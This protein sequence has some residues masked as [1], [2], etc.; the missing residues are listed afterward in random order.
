MFSANGS[1]KTCALVHEVYWAAFGKNPVTGAITKSPCKIV[2]VLDASDKI[3]EVFIPEWK[4][5]YDLPDDWCK[6]NGKPYVVEI[7]FPN[8]STLT[9]YSA[10]SDPMKFEGFMAD[11]VIIDEPLPRQLMIAL[12]RS[13]RIKGSPARLLFFGTAVSQA[14]LRTE[15]YEP[16]AKGDLPGAECFRVGIE[17]N[18]QNLADGYIENF[19]RGLSEA[20][21]ETRLKGGFFDSDSVAL[22]HLWKREQHIFP[23]EDFTYNPKWPCVVAIDPHTS[24]PH[25]AIMIT[26]PIGDRIFAIKELRL[27]GNATQFA[28]ALKNWMQGYTVIDIVSDSAGNADGTALEGFDSFIKVLQQNG[29][30]VRGTRFKEKSH[31]DLVGRLQNGLVIPEEPDQFGKKLPKLRVL[32]TLTSLISDIE[33]ATWQKN[34]ATGETIPKIDTGIRDHLSCLGYALAT[35]LFRDKL[36]HNKP[37]YKEH[38]AEA[39]AGTKEERTERRNS[40]ISQRRGRMLRRIAT[41]KPS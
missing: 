33:G 11:Y 13:L 39:V 10:E 12:R 19:S 6:K 22:G 21:K 38:L 18:R 40:I 37:I 41:R 5:W 4:K 29:I 2:V 27:K 25:T 31:E 9:F 23:V 34:R 28:A 8:G 15:I 36:L 26:S 14:W 3:G 16:W 32:S 1:G 17:A 35:G 20:E 30:A 7:N 24:K